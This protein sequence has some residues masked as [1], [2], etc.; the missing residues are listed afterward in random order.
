MDRVPGDRGEMKDAPEHRNT[1]RSFLINEARE[2]GIRSVRCKLSSELRLVGEKNSELNTQLQQIDNGAA[3]DQAG[4]GTT[5]FL[6]QLML[7]RFYMGDDGKQPFIGQINFFTL[8]RY[9]SDHITFL[10]RQ[11]VNVQSK[12]VRNSDGAF[13]VDGIIQKVMHEFFGIML[14]CVLS[15]EQVRLP[16]AYVTSVDGLR[17]LDWPLFFF[18]TLFKLLDDDIAQEK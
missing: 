1:Y 17:E 8:C 4:E 16:V 6:P 15:D 5:P 11:L 18:K 7:P 2:K 3:G 10:D 9:G 13:T 14:T 12:T